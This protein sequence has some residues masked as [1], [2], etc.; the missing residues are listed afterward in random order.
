MCFSEELLL[1]LVNTRY[2][3]F[4][5]SS[6]LASATIK[7]EFSG[8]FR[9]LAVNVDYVVPGVQIQEIDIAQPG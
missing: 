2:Q 4:F 1:T 8:S 7:L 9:Y 5:T 3:Y 6:C